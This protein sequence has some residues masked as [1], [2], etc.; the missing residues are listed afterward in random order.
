MPEQTIDPERRPSTGPDPDGVAKASPRKVLVAAGA[1]HFVEWFDLGIYGTLSTIIA[2][3]FFAD[4]DETAA[5]L[6]TFAVFAAGFVVRPLG[7]LFF[8]PLAD[9]IG[10]KRVLAIIVLVTSLTTFGMGVLPTYATIG[11]AA[12]LLLVAL[13]L[14]QG[15]AAGGETSSAVSM[16]FEYAPRNRRGYYTSWSAAIGFLAFVVGSGLALALTAG[17]GDAT[18]SS[19]GW[20]V[21][22]L[23]ALPLGM[24]GLYLRL[25]MEDTPEFRA[26]KESGDISDSPTRE[27]FRTARVAMLVL[28]GIMVI[29]GVGHW[30]LQTF[31]VSYLQ[32]TMDFSKVHSFLAATVCLAV[33]AVLVPFMGL[34]SDKIGRRPLL[35]GGTAGMLVLAWP[36][37]QLM[38]L[39]NTAFAILGMVLLGLPLAAYDGAINAVMAELFP[40]RIRSGAIA[41]PYNMSVTLFGGTAPYVATWLIGAT[42]NDFSPA[43]YLMLAAAVTLITVLRWVKETSGPKADI[44]VEG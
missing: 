23:L 35:I 34:L 40:P 10:R 26:M 41:I 2:A 7:G 38:A 32:N 25:K 18:M 28:A 37:L 44:T 12:P 3:N 27:T 19:W 21:P 39:H 4:G 42:G 43:F 14:I 11:A 8:G 17:L 9:R 36:A 15:F 20:R 6:S 33:V 29:K 30:M 5:L 31:M 1:G 22:F 24:T 16:L 13:R